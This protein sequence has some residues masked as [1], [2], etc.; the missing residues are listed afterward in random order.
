MFPSQ[1]VKSMVDRRM[2]VVSR[3]PDGTIRLYSK[4]ADSVMLSRLRPNQ[5]S[6]LL[7]AAQQALRQYSLQVRNPGPAIPQIMLGAAFL[8]PQPPRPPSLCA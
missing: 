8:T 6:A 3:A 1:S 7:T 4:G 2:S 5:P